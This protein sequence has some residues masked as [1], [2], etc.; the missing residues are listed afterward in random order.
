MENRKNA[1]HSSEDK[2]IIRTSCLALL[3]SLIHLIFPDNDE[4]MEVRIEMKRKNLFQYRDQHSFICIFHVVH[5]FHA[6]H[7]SNSLV[8]SQA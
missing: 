2:Y 5:I 3:I 1:T 7:S 8:G 4:V 6:T